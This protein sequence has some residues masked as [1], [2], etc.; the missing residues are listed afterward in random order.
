MTS[1]IHSIR[2]SI[3]KGL[4]A[5]SLLNVR[6]I[7]FYEMIGICFGKN[8]ELICSKLTGCDAIFPH[9]VL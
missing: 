8:G 9:E 1:V 6:G 5:I 2:N 4:N 3:N 7:S